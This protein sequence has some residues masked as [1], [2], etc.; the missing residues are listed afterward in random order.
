MATETVSTPAAQLSEASTR[1]SLLDPARYGWMTA[2]EAGVALGVTPQAI[3]RACREGRIEGRRPLWLGKWLV[4]S[5]EI[6]RLLEEEGDY[7]EASCQR[8]DR[9]VEAE[10]V[11]HG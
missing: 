5:C 4:P 7:Y 1:I 11:R 10:G 2:E 3:R 8:H 9:L 6:R